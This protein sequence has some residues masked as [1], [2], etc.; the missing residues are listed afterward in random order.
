MKGPHNFHKSL[1]KITERAS[2]NHVNS[3][4]NKDGLDSTFSKTDNEVAI[5]FNAIRSDA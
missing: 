4:R 3:L 2:K 5:C 1:L